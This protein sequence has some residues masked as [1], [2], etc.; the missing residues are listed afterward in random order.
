MARFVIKYFNLQ[1]IPPP[2]REA[3]IRWNG[4]EARNNYKRRKFPLQRRSGCLVKGANAINA[5]YIPSV[6]PSITTF[7]TLRFF[8]ALLSAI[9][10]RDAQWV[11]PHKH[12]IDL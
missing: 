11:A 12:S 4:F 1:K 6:R 9:P 2:R 3:F 10:P 8:R 7:T 5:I